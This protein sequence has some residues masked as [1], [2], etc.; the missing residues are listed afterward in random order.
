M[1]LKDIDKV[2]ISD[3]V[4]INGQKVRINYFGLSPLLI[5]G[6][7]E[8]GEKKITRNEY[9]EKVKRYLLS[10][11]SV[12]DDGEAINVFSHLGEKLEE[13]SASEAWSKTRRIRRE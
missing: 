11:E 9:V 10:F 4:R 1:E 13:I 6:D 12:E 2:C 3:E 8:D 5:Q 7:E